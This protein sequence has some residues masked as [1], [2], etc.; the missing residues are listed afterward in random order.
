MQKGKMV[1]QGG[2]AKMRKE[3]TQEARDKRKD[4]PI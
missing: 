1:V 2:L 4:I 3:K